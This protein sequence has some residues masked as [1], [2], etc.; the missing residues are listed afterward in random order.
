MSP[1]NGSDLAKAIEQFTEQQTAQ[2]QEAYGFLI[3]K[4]VSAFTMKYS[5]PVQGTAVSAI[6]RLIKRIDDDSLRQ[7]RAMSEPLL[8]ADETA[9]REDL[10]EL[11]AQLLPASSQTH[12][13]K[14]RSAFISTI[15][16]PFD[17]KYAKRWLE[18]RQ[19]MNSGEIRNQIENLERREL[20]SPADLFRWTK[21][22]IELFNNVVVFKGEEANQ[23]YLRPAGTISPKSARTYEQAWST[24][25]DLH[26]SQVF[27][28]AV[29]TKR[30][31]NEVMVDLS[32]SSPSIR[33]QGLG[34]ALPE[35]TLTRVPEPTA[36]QEIL[37]SYEIKT[38]RKAEPLKVSSPRVKTSWIKVELSSI[39]EATAQASRKWESRT[40]FYE[41][42]DSWISSLEEIWGTASLELTAKILVKTL[43]GESELT[44][45]S[46][47]ID[48]AEK[49][50]S[51]TVELLQRF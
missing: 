27:D 35:R 24:F 39:I 2:A 5:V 38:P 31:K 29:E 9:L 33:E 45:P 8:R 42:L 4:L 25:I 17:Y 3:A 14:T 44:I 18:E 11:Q 47:S 32:T 30:H 50:I 49:R 7:I 41:S 15:L 1:I 40:S 43:D 23:Y 16:R 22:V 10:L 21:E 12:Q 46:L 51:Q 6:S 20:E 26:L 48:D 37:M 36:D 34:Q 28:I 19:D 13:V